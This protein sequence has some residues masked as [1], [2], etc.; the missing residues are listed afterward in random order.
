MLN[1]ETFIISITSYGFLPLVTQP[2]RFCDTTQSLIDNIFCNTFD[3]DSESGNILIEFADHLTQF[4]SI[5]K[6]LHLYLRSD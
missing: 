5:K 1:A 6:R 3:Q 2:T 4:A